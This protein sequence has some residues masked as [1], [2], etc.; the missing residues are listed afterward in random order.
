MVIHLVMVGIAH[1]QEGPRPVEISVEDPLDP[2]ILPHVRIQALQHIPT[3]GKFNAF[4][5]VYVG[6]VGA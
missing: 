6:L 3:N 4:N 2:L 5:S 1:I